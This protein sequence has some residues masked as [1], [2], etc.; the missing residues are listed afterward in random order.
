MR[1]EEARLDAQIEEALQRPEIR[2]LMN[3]VPCHDPECLY[4]NCGAT[5]DSSTSD[6]EEAEEERGEEEAREGT[7]DAED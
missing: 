7:G 6:S 2:E 3:H 1:A 4:Q 5:S